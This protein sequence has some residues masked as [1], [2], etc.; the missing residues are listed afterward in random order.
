M[1]KKSHFVYLTEHFFLWVP[2]D[3]FC[4]VKLLTIKGFIISWYGKTRV[5]SCE[6]KI[7]KS[8]VEI[9]KQEFK[10]KRSNSRVTSSKSQ[11]TSSNPRVM[12]LIP[13]ITS[14]NLQVTST[15]PWV[16]SSN[17]RVTNF[18]PNCWISDQIYSKRVF[19]V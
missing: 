4:A 9:Q 2:A 13:R 7:S 14:S 17:P 12:T 10:S 6:L 18:T 16:L 3:P 19:P 1:Q 11:V 5:T 8:R 15:T